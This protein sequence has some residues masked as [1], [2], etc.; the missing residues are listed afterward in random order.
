MRLSKYLVLGLVTLLLFVA[1]VY[2]ML[3]PRTPFWPCSGARPITLA[4]GES[5]ASTTGLEGKIEQFLKLRRK[6]VDHESA[7]EKKDVKKIQQLQQTFTALKDELI[8]AGVDINAKAAEDDKWL[9][10][11]EFKYVKRK[12]ACFISN[13]VGA[14]LGH[15]TFSVKLR[16]QI[17]SPDVTRF[18]HELAKRFHS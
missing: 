6:I 15:I 10:S 4:A 5:T 18:I 12:L 11:K 1:C 8:K 14:I 7:P 3:N 16:G 13:F 9:K 2:G 17:V